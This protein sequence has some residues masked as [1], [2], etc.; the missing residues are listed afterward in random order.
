MTRGTQRLV[1][2]RRA[3]DTAQAKLRN[4]TIVSPRVNRH[5]KRG[6]YAGARVPD[7]NRCW[8]AG[9]VIEVRRAYRLTTNRREAAALDRILA[10]CDKPELEP[11]VGTLQSPS[12]LVPGSRSAAGGDALA[13]NDDNRNG[14]VACKEA[15]RHE[16][17]P[18]PR[19]HPA[20]RFMRNADNDGIVCE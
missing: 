12:G 13:L 14:R 15:R 9:R 3:L 7:R 17:A 10:R 20:Y 4:L 6:K 2:S 5:Q 8:F 1:G 18:V 19:S 16:A 11:V